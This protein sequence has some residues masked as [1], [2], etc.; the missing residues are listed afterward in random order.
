MKNTLLSSMILTSCFV[1]ATASQAAQK[2]A[3]KLDSILQAIDSMDPTQFAKLLTDDSKF[4]FGNFPEAVGKEAIAKAQTDF[5]SNIKG[6]KH[7]VVHS[8]HDKSSIVAEMNVTYTRHDGS[9]VT[10]PVTDVFKIK[11]NKVAG[12]YIYMDIAPLYTTK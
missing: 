12:T 4:K 8:W 11:N 3:I 6:L 2:E 9:T 1:M 10:L 7:E 5:Y